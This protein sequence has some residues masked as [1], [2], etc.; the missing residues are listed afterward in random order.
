MTE[1]SREVFDQQ[2]KPRF[3]NANPE[4]MSLSFWEWMIRDSPRSPDT[5]EGPLEESGL[6]MRE[7]M[8]KSMYGPYRARDFFNIP[9]NR[10]E[11]PIWTF[12]RMGSTRS[13]LPDGRVICVGGE[14][15]DFYDPDF[16]IY[17]DVVVLG[18][19]D[20]IEIYGYPKAVFPPTDFH[21][22]TVAAKKIVIIGGLGYVNERRPG[23]TPAYMLDLS[24]YCIGEIATSGEMPGWISEH[25]ASWDSVKGIITIKGGQVVRER[26]GRQRICRNYEDYALD[27]QSWVWQRLTDRNW[28]EFSIRQEKGVFMLEQKPKVESLLPRDVGQSVL[29]PEREENARFIVAGV[30]VSLEIG[31]RNIRILVEGSLPEA[32]SARMVEEIRANAE[33]AIRR[34]CVLEE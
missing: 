2:R 9:L 10:E 28:R 19:D 16:Y 23:F 1:I 8:L 24:G 26:G 31:V 32:L 18:P 12:D 34:R 25:E 22:A 3:G 14:H 29:P 30:P 13:V 17:N 21:T 6:V 5:E 33:A 15:E 20:Q 11:G 7:G 4:R 27:L